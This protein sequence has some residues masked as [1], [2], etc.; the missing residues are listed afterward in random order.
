V[1]SPRNSSGTAGSGLLRSE[2]DFYVPWFSAD[3]RTSLITVPADSHRQLFLCRAA[4]AEPNLLAS[5]GQV[6]ADDS[7]ALV[8]WATRWNL[9]DC[10]CLAL[11]LDTVRWYAREPKAEGWE[12]E[13]KGTYAGFFPF[14]IEPLQLE[15]FYFDPTWRRREGFKRFVL[16]RVAKALDGYCDRIELDALAA[17]LKRVPRKR[18]IEHFDWLAQYQLKGISFQSIAD[19]A[20]YKFKGGRQT[21]RKAIVEL[22]KIHLA[23]LAFVNLLLDSSKLTPQ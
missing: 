11:A 21:V 19:G 23:H 4:L 12:F 14:A 3:G 7:E 1:R 2:G 8:K 18:E 9:T 20:S 16:D 22:G 15:P 5:L 10:W 6:N 13:G 17:G